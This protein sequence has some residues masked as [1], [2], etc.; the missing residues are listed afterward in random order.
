MVGEKSYNSEIVVSNMDI[1]PTYRSLLKNHYH[2][3]KDIKSREIK[4]CSN[5]LLG[6]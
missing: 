1:V 2:P 6:H 4:L 5:I 3:E